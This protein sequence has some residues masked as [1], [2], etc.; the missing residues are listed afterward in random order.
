MFSITFRNEPQFSSD[1]A[2]QVK[3]E[4]NFQV[5]KIKLLIAL[6]DKELNKEKDCVDII[7][8]NIGTEVILRR[9]DMFIKADVGRF[10][11]NE[12]TYGEDGEP[13]AII[14]TPKDTNLLKVS[15]RRCEFNKSLN[16]GPSYF[17][18]EEA[19]LSALHFKDEFQSTEQIID[20]QLS[21]LYLV[22]HQEAIL[23]I[24]SLIQ[25]VLVPLSKADEAPYI[26]IKKAFVCC[27]QQNKLVNGRIR[28]NETKES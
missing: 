19:H 8:E 6:T 12:M 24:M 7:I 3:I 15:Y 13:L 14:S 20:V 17:Y 21:M 10:V 22:L 9:W 25:Q 5:K 11:L 2:N 16:L 23:S 18:S 1:V 27:R 26:S 4:L 28:K